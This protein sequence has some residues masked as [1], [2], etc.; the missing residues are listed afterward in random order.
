MESI[1]DLER[2]FAG[3]IYPNRLPI[4]IALTGIV[5]VMAVVAWR[6]AWCRLVRLH[7]GRATAGTIAFLV[8]AGP[9]GWY[10]GSPL[11]LSTTIDEPP[12]VAAADPAPVPST[13]LRAPSPLPPP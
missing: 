6:L 12:P 1:G 4:A 10:L 7:P 9:L 3:A 2:A 5:A 13:A 8:V 11:V